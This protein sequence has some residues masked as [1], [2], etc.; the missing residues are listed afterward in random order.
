MK[1]Q[2][3]SDLHCGVA[4]LKQITIGPQVDIVV[5]AGDICEGS[6]NSFR[7]LRQIVPERIPIVMT[8]G[9]HEHYHR[10]LPEELA[11][12]R[13]AAPD[14][15]VVLL[16]NDVAVIDGVRFLGA[17][18]WTDYGLFGPQ[19]APAAMN[20]ARTALNDHRLIG[21][22]KE[23]WKRFRPE[24]AAL[25][26]ARSKAFFTEAIAAPFAG[27][28]VAVSHHAPD[29]RSLAKRF[30]SS[31]I[32][33]AFV[34]DVLEEL[35]RATR[36]EVGSKD[37]SCSVGHWIHG[38]THDSFDYRAGATRVLCN[39]HGYGSENADFDPVLVIEV[40]E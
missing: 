26:N 35:L 18:M 16:E 11:K 5:V 27:P 29:A 8:L 30:E 9:N 28:T 24:E 3:F 13:A 33:A 17:T 12:G 4:Q 19:N 31:L 38:H 34:S 40:G 39:P 6:V 23:P 14:Y 32:S 10:F 2:I 1:L 15:N 7:H 37:V 20:A 21:W 25:L 36:A 22:Q